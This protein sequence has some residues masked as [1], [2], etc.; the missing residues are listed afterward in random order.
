V[1]LDQRAGRRDAPCLVA[2]SIVSA[3]AREEKPRRLSFSKDFDVMVQ[4]IVVDLLASD[5]RYRQ[6][7]FERP[8][9]PVSSSC[10]LGRPGMSPATP[11]LP[12]S[13]LVAR[14]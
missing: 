13:H 3:V 9:D 1:D 7:C 4:A 12:M 6:G 14:V 11:T 10:C 5:P 2:S 8:S